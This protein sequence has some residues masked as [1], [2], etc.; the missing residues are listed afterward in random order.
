MKL[1]MIK[2]RALEI[3]GLAIEHEIR[4]IEDPKRLKRLLEVSLP[5]LVEAESI[6]TR[7]NEKTNKL[8]Q[9]R[10]F[11]CFKS[12]LHFGS[13]KA[14]A[15]FYYELHGGLTLGSVGVAI[16]NLNHLRAET[17]FSE[18][19]TLVIDGDHRWFEL[20]DSKDM[21]EPNQFYATD[22]ELIHAINSQLET[23]EQQ[24]EQAA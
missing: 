6:V 14:I 11:G 7:L 4:G 24:L 9:K 23:T 13:D 20:R 18:D 16:T 17:S 5:E 2:K 12:Y 1:T 3:I 19:V 22:K 21:L 10:K 8:R 15:A